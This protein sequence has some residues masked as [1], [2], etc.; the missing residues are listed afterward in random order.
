MLDILLFIRAT[1]APCVVPQLS[2]IRIV[3]YRSFPPHYSTFWRNDC[4]REDLIA[5]NESLEVTTHTA[6]FAYTQ[7]YDG[8]MP[9]GIGDNVSFHL[10]TIFV[11]FHDDQIRSST[12]G[13]PE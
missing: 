6:G 8:Q 5:G 4:T 13:S 12:L 2:K 10:E 11:F 3:M 1:I 9:V 7:G